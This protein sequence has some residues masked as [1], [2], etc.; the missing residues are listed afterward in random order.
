[1]YRDV[2]VYY[3]MCSSLPGLCSLDAGNIIPVMVFKKCLQ[4]MPNAPREAKILPPSFW[5]KT[6]G[7]GI[8][9]R[10]SIES[11]K[12]AEEYSTTHN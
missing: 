4:T 3:K 6:V 8:L 2:F 5:L 9:G 7:L 1:M 12:Y 11:Q 10:L